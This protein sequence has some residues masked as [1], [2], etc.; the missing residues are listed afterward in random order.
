MSDHKVLLTNVFTIS[1]D[2]F[3]VSAEKYSQK[4]G[5]HNELPL[6]VEKRVWI[7]FSSCMFYRNSIKVSNNINKQ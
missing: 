4:F 3:N 2:Q 1:F 7:F 6:N 5:G